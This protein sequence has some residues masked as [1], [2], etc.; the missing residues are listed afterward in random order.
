MKCTKGIDTHEELKKLKLKNNGKLSIGS[1]NI[2]SLSEKFDELKLFLNGNL[3]IIIIQETKLDESFP[4]AQFAMPGYSKPFRQDRNRFGGGIMIYVKESLPCRKLTKHHFSENVEGLFIEINLRK[5]KLL[6]FGGYRSEHPVYGINEKN[7]FHQISLALDI[8]RGYDRFLIAGD[9]NCEM[10]NRHA[11]A[12]LSDH[13][14]SNLVK[15]ATCYKNVLNPSCIDVFL[16]NCSNAFQNTS[17]LCTGI[18]DFHN[19]IVTIF[20][21]AIPPNKPKIIHYRKFKNFNKLSFESELITQLSQESVVNYKKFEE[22]FIEIL[23]KYAPAKIKVLR[24]NNKPFMSKELCKAIMKRTMLKNKYHKNKTLSSQMEYKK[25]KNYTNRL[26]KK[27]KA[28]RISKLNF[29]NIKGS[30]EFWKCIG[31]FFSNNSIKSQQITLVKDDKIVS[32]DKEVADTFSKFFKNATNSLDISKNELLLSDA[33]E[34]NDP[35]QIAVKKFKC[36]PSILEIQKNTN[37]DFLFQFQEICPSD[38]EEQIQAL[39]NKKAITFMNIPTYIL[40][41]VVKIVSPTLCTIWNNQL[42]K[43][44][45]FANTLKLADVYPIHKKLEQISEKNYRPVSVLPVISK[46]F[47]RIMQKQMSNFVN[48]FLSPY[49]CGYR[50]G[51]SPQYALLSMIEKWKKSLDKKGFAGGI[52]MDLSKAFDTINHDLLI[53]KLHAYGFSINSLK[54]LMSYLSDRFQRI[55]INSTF[56]SWEQLLC[57]VPQ[58]SIL[59]PILFNI[60]LNDL[61]YLLKQTDICNLADDTTPYACDTDIVSLISRL[62]NDALIAIVWFEANYMKINADK[63]HLLLSGNVEQW[64]W[65]KVGDE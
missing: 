32:D 42:I 38:I 19:L 11:S 8:Y 65:A 54:V 12:F 6:I 28:D 34:F 15:T 33:S 47:E 9:F 58:G 27:E 50:K 39:N 3:D 7:F 20:K 17:S 41:N 23:N 40:K 62:E 5:S 1:L 52:L 25:H 14:A 59:G 35:V 13:K 57:G 26:A 49:L 48:N 60:Y 4:E 21:T 37:S 51:Y 24:S 61:F 64:H 22:I 30:K 53:A 18:S 56:S 46:I 55:K 2:N 45:D 16:T 10:S 44:S 43:N 31:P 63:C 29:S 36:H